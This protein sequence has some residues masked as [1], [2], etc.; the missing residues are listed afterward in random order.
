MLDEKKHA[1]YYLMPENI[2]CNSNENWFLYD[3]YYVVGNQGLEELLK[4]K[5]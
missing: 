2:Y 3:G 5:Q 1:N 4:K